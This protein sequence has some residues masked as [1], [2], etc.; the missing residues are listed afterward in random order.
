MPSLPSWGCGECWCGDGYERFSTFIHRLRRVGSPS[1]VE[2]AKSLVK[3]SLGS[4]NAGVQT[5]VCNARMG[6][7]LSFGRDG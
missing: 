2:N 6:I 7:S 1:V 3:L 5:V 4:V